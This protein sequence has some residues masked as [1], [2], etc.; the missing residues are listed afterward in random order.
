MKRMQHQGKVPK[1]VVTSYKR[2]ISGEVLSIDGKLVRI[3]AS[4]FLECR[5]VPLS[6]AEYYA[7]HVL[8]YQYI[9]NED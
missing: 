1:I 6:K 7:H 2:N 4:L 9:T 8:C 3:L 5:Y